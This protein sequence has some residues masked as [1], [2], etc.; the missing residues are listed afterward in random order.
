M[1][2]AIEAPELLDVEMDQLTGVLPLVPPNRLWWFE[3]P[4]AVEAQAA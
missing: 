3:H 4:Y 1:A 2:R